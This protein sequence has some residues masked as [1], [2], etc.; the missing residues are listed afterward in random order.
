MNRNRISASVGTVLVTLMPAVSTAQAP[1][2][3]N[4][5]VLLPD[6]PYRQCELTYV[7]GRFGGRLEVGVGGPTEISAGFSGGG[8]VR[9]VAAVPDAARIASRGQAFQGTANTLRVL[10]VVG[11]AV[12]WRVA[13]RSPDPRLARVFTAGAGVT[14][15]FLFPVIPQSMACDEFH[16][17]TDV[18]NRQLAR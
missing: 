10:A 14:A 2:M 18:Y 12:L 17:A 8:I 5:T 1:T 15:F 9:A 11:T 7:P 13:G 6:C 16:Q 3:R 4:A